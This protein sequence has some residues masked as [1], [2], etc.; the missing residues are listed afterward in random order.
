MPW[1][2]YGRCNNFEIVALYFMERAQVLQS[3]VSME[4]ITEVDLIEKAKTNDA[5]FVDLYNIYFPK[6]YGYV[7]RRTGQREMAEDIVSVVFIKVFTNLKKYKYQDCSFS[8]WVYKIATN[9]LTDHY[10][11]TA[12]HREIMP[13]EMP[14]IKDDKQNITE[15]IELEGD[16]AVVRAVIKQLPVRYEEVLNLK[17]FAELSNQEIAASLNI[18]ANNVGV[19]IHRALT[20]FE[21]TYQNYVH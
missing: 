5:A 1:F 15:A 8:A 3:T 18:K 14:E 7:V 20:A 2:C 16:K 19:L 21:R 6:I 10:R 9:S 12:R 17:F 13:E 4:H 11:K